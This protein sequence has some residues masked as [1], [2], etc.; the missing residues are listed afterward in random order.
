[1]KA[2]KQYFLV[3]LFTVL[4]KVAQTFESVDERKS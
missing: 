4:Y 3:V 2:A 1:M